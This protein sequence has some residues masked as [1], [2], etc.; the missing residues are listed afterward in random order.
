M[1][2]K[3]SIGGIWE[4]TT[5]AGAEKLTIKVDEDLKAGVYYTVLLNQS[6]TEY[7]TLIISIR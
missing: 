1:D 3:K 6:K 7:P 5:Q 2:E 4:G